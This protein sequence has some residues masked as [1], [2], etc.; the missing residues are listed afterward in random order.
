MSCVTVRFR[1]IPSSLSRVAG[2]IPVE[3]G[4]LC[5]LT[6]LNMAGNLLAGAYGMNC[7]TTRL[8]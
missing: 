7:S 5:N 4:K 3:L 2:L 8:G 6:N 1:I